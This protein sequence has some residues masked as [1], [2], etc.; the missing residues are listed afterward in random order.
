MQT[1]H[2]SCTA[3]LKITGKIKESIHFQSFCH[4]VHSDRG[5]RKQAKTLTSAWRLCHSLLPFLQVCWK[6]PKDSDAATRQ[7]EGGNGRWANK[8]PWH[9]DHPNVGVQWVYVAEDRCC[10]GICFTGQ[11]QWCLRRNPDWILPLKNWSNLETASSAKVPRALEKHLY[12]S[13]LR[14]T[15]HCQPLNLS[16]S[17]F[18]APA[19]ILR[20]FRI[21]KRACYP[22]V[23]GK[24]ENI[25]CTNPAKTE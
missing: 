14:S 16:L 7:G 6:Q 13:C 21:F 12:L 4:P 22:S 10:D 20:D 24:T 19:T 3:Q 2:Q 17:S 1:T 11:K 5:R 9:D 8:S 23:R 15:K 25:Q 18:K